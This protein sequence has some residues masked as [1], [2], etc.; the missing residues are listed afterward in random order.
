MALTSFYLSCRAE[1]RQ[2]P[3][4]TRVLCSWMDRVTDRWIILLR[5]DNTKAF[6][7]LEKAGSA[8]SGHLCVEVKI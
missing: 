7:L 2:S 8:L 5:T 3:A 4:F 1:S 6:R